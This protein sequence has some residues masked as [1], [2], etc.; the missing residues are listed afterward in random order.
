MFPWEVHNGR[1]SSLV[2]LI[3]VISAIG[4]APASL[5]PLSPLHLLPSF[6]LLSSSSPGAPL[7]E[8][9]FLHT[10]FATASPET[11]SPRFFLLV[12][13]WKWQRDASHLGVFVSFRTDVTRGIID[14]YRFRLRRFFITIQDFQSLAIA[15]RW[16]LY[17]RKLEKINFKLI[18][19]CD[20]LNERR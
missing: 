14:R 19:H 10:G 15:L 16:F 5:N 6:Y 20:D 2:Q 4:W 12:R 1:S 18:F 8:R 13:K 9:P 11:P 7:G 17:E 3:S